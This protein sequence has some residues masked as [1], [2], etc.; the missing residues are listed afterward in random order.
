MKTK[1]GLDRITAE[2]MVQFCMMSAMGA[3]GPLPWESEAL[4]GLTA[5]V[6]AR[7][8]KVVGK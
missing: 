4:A 2:G 6:L 5:F 3:Q 1:T 8:A 7:H